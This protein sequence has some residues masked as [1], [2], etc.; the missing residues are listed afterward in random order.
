MHGNGTSVTTFSWLPAVNMAM[1][2]FTAGKAPEE[3]N[4]KV[5]ARAQELGVTM[6][7]TAGT[8]TRL[9]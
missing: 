7:D 5:I 2:V 9:L 6:L 1:K 8:T 4:L 3:D